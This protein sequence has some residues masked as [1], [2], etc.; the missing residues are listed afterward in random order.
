MYVACDLKPISGCW[1][2]ANYAPMVFGRN[3]KARTM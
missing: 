1:P 2:A 3:T